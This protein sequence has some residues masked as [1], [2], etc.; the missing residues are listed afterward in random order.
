[1][2]IV[3][4]RS[5]ALQDQ[6]ATNKRR[7]LNTTNAK[8]L[9]KPAI[10]GALVPDD[11]AMIIE[12]KFVDDPFGVSREEVCSFLI[13][14]RIRKMFCECV[15]QSVAAAKQAIVDL[16]RTFPAINATDCIDFSRTAEMCVDAGVDISADMKFWFTVPGSTKNLSKSLTFRELWEKTRGGN[17][18]H[19][20]WRNGS[21]VSKDYDG[22]PWKLEYQQELRR[23]HIQTKPEIMLDFTSDPDDLELGFSQPPH[24]TETLFG[25]F[26]DVDYN[27]R[28]IPEEDKNLWRLLRKFFNPSKL[29]S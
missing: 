13:K 27:I 20:Y 1:M 22:A 8:I 28:R 3:G 10:G 2:E 29:S 9:I 4:D 18:L 15:W 6:T 5:A 7:K 17:T 19:W 24:L 12:T 14:L 26:E 25:T 16:A 23:L 21:S 11:K